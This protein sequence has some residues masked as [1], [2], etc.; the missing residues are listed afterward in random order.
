MTRRSSLRAQARRIYCDTAAAKAEA[1]K[2]PS[3]T[4]TR[5]RGREQAAASGRGETKL[6]ARVRKLY[7]ESA[8]PVAAIARLAGVA[9]RTVYKYARKGNW[10]PR[11]AWTGDGARPPSRPARGRLSAPGERAQFAPVRGAGARFVARA[12]RGKP[13][14]RGLK[15]TDR[16][17]ERR[18][19]ALCAGAETLATQSQA[20]AEWHAW[21]AA[22]LDTLKTAAS[23]R[24]ALAVHRKKRQQQRA[25]L[26]AGAPDF[27][28]QTLER[29][30]L[31]AVKCLQ[32]CQAHSARCV[33]RMTQRA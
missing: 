14:A 28:E 11:Y 9:E 13:F 15:A 1:N 8:V 2:A 21:Q 17:A 25:Q 22:F 27:Y 33:A 4:L 7:E 18:A 10:Q 3:L 23:L 32:L 6:T 24:D 19:A 30:G 20:E 29:A 12:D 26:G 31:I 5:E 16:A